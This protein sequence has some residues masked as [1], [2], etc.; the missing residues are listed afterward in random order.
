MIHT[1]SEKQEGKK[2][3]EKLKEHPKIKVSTVLFYS[4]TLQKANIK[5]K[6]ISHEIDRKVKLLTF[7]NLNEFNL[8]GEHENF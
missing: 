1:L 3:K 5:L 8:T 7:S 2:V 6:Y 4:K